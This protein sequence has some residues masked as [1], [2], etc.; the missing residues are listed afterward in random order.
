MAFFSGDYRRAI[1]LLDAAAQQPGA[2]P[3]ARVFLACAKVSLV[4]TG[5]GDAAL[6]REARADFQSVD[7]TRNLTDEQRRFISPRVLQQLETP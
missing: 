6:L 1:P 5:G 2:S 7:L 4:L 3:R